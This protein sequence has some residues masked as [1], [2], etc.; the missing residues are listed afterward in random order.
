MTFAT[1]EGHSLQRACVTVPK[2]GLWWADAH[3]VEP[4]TLS[5]AVALKLAD[6]ELNGT[7]IAGGVAEGKAS[8]RIVGGAGGWGKA[9]SQPKKPYRN[10]AGMKISSVIGDAARIVGE[11]VE[12]V[13]TT[14]V[15]QHYAMVNGTASDVLNLLTPRS[16]R[17]DFDGVTRFG[18][19]ET[20]VYEGEG[21]VTRIVPDGSIFEIATDEIGDLLPGVTVEGSQPATDVE[22]N[23]TSEKLTVKVYCGTDSRRLRAWRKLVLALFPWLQY[24]GVFEYVVVSQTGERLNLQPLRVATGMPE[25]SGVP[26][27]PGVASFKS[28]AT[29]GAHVLV[30]FADRD[31]SRPQVIAHDAPDAPGFGLTVFG[32]ALL[33]L[34]RVGDPVA[35]AGAILPNPTT[36]TIAS[37]L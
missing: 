6:K 4:E 26:V 36:P 11:T 9:I 24:V 37:S 32:R 28:T 3:L 5:G 15:G 2:W 29:P 22:Y 20:V 25:L 13:P 7:I 31:P 12:D 14:R 23:L 8:Y 19:R 34:A 18:E 33:P 16:W 17:V 27:R 21:T 1:L 10:D 30:A 35:G